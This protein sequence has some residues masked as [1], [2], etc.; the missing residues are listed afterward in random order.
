[1]QLP[2]ALPG[3]ISGRL[4]LPATVWPSS[5]VCRLPSRLRPPAPPPVPWQ[6]EKLHAGTNR[7]AATL[8]RVGSKLA[9]ASAGVSMHGGIGGRPRS[10][11]SSG[12]RY[13]SPSI[14]SW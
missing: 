6:D 9:T 3:S 14:S 7:L 13:S 10:S 2:S 5:L 11:G 8:V 12:G 4:L 1:S